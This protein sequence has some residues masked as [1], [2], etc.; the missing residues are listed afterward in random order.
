MPLRW[1]PLLVRHFAR[2]LDAR[3]AGARVRALRLD[4]AARRMT[5]LMREAT[6]DW[7]LHPSLGAPRLLPPAEPAA[8]DL[9]LR[10]RLRAVRSEADERIL[11][12]ELLPARGQG[13]RDLV[14]ELLGNQWNALVVERPSGTIRHVLVRRGGPRPAHVGDA[15]APPRPSLREGVSEPISVSRWREILEPV[16]PPQRERALVAAVAWTSSLNAAALVDGNPDPDVALN[17]GHALWAALSFGPAEPSPVLLEGERG[18][19]PYPWPLPGH[20]ARPVPSLLEA[21]RVIAEREPVDVAGPGAPLLPPEL[22][23]ALEAALDAELRR[24]TRLRAELDALEDERA[25][26]RRADLLLARFDQVPRGAARATLVGLDGEGVTVDLDPALSVQ[27][28]ARA[29]YDRAARVARARE[30]LPGLLRDVEVRC[31]TLEALRDRAHAGEADA[32]EVRRAL[33]AREAPVAG[34]ATSEALPYR[35]FRSSGGLEIRVGKGARLNDELTFRH[36]R[37]GDVWLHAR[38][39]VGAHVVLRWGGPGNPPA[40]DLEEAAILAALHS[41]ARTSGLAPVDWT[42]RKHVRKPCGAP[43]GSVVPDRAKTLL[44]RPDPR[45]LEKL[46]AE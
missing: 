4:G 40:R 3:L 46:A 39:A 12:L 10:A 8:S 44:V 31:R 42:F 1:D 35:T 9:S 37:P 16:P 7:P 33:P 18:E 36:A 15:Y 34:P 38:D 32:E 6:L 11:A 20:P 21:F 24:S 17:E 2:E 19:Q 23:S 41:K 25:L 5:L 43:P 27:D 13:A 28:N 14:I 29:L 30:R 22:V 26:R 45:V